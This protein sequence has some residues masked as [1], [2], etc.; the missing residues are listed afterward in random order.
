MLTTSPAAVPQDEAAAAESS[1][2]TPEHK[3]ALKG[4]AAMLAAGKPQDAAVDHL[5]QSNMPR[6]VAKVLVKQQLRACA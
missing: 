6:L 5:V 2:L 3:Q 1:G 4:A